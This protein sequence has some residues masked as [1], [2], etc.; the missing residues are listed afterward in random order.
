MDQPPELTVS[1]ARAWDRPLV[2]VPAFAA[3]SLIGGAF[4]SF[5]WEANIWV[6]LLGPVLVWMGMASRAGREPAIIRMGIGA[7][8]WSVPA[9]ML[10]VIEAVNFLL[11]STYDHPTLSLLADPLFEGYIA[12]SLGYFAWVSAFWGLVRR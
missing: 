7:A 2:L 12:R 9:A 11:G 4:A 5:S 1:L 8:W 3:V 6:L 10:I